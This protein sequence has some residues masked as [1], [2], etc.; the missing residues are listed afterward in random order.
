MIGPVCQ[1][2]TGPVTGPQ[3]GGGVLGSAPPAGPTYNFGRVR[4]T[5]TWGAPT[6]S[7]AELTFRNAAEAAQTGAP[8]FSTEAGG[9]NTAAM[10]FDANAA[11][12]WMPTLA[13]PGPMLGLDFDAETA[14]GSVV[15]QHGP[16]DNE[17]ESAPRSFVIDGSA[18]GADWDVLMTVTNEPQWAPGE[19][20][21]YTI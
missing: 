14:V 12:S 17:F 20:R 4:F 16:V 18:N 7:I 11:T 9:M 21:I 19:T 15:I 2:I 8:I 10:A 13:D 3:V 5:E 6:V 1:S